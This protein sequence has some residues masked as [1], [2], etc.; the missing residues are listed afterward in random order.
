MSDELLGVNAFAVG[1]ALTVN[2]DEYAELFETGVD[3]ESVTRTFAWKL[4][5]CESAVVYVAENIWPLVDITALF[6]EFAMVNM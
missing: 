2:V 6:S 1:F 5:A 4:P 3:A